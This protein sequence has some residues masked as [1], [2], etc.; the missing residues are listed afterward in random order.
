MAQYLI[1]IYEQEGFYQDPSS[2][3]WQTAM[4][5]TP[6]VRS[7]PAGSTSSRPDRAAG[8]DPDPRLRPGGMRAARRTTIGK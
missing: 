3:A 6:S 1:L 4:E 8:G 2:E 5:A 7:W